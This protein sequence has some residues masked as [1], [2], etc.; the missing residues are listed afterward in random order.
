M[1]RTVPLSI[2]T[3]LIYLL[4]ARLAV[5]GKRQIDLFDSPCHWLY[6]M[7][8]ERLC[9]SRHQHL[10]GHAIV[11]GSPGRAKGLLRHRERPLRRG[12]KGSAPWVTWTH[13]THRTTPIQNLFITRLL[14]TCRS[15]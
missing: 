5:V 3:H 7:K 6:L 8:S 10:R 15:R 14:L 4:G 11:A 13:T 9:A 12:V 2:G 1:P